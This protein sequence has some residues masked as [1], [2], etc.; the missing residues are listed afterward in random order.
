LLSDNDL[1]QVQAASQQ[2]TGPVTIRVSRGGIPGPFEENLINTCRQITGVSQNRIELEESLDSVIPGK[3]SLTIVGAGVP[4][5]HYLAVPEG[6]EFAPF[7]DALMWVGGAKQ[8]TDAEVYEPLRAVT[9]P[10]DLLVLIAPVCPH[11]PQVVRAAVSVGVH[12]SLVRV[13]VGDALQF[14]D[15]AEQ[16]KVKS[17][18]TTVID[19]GLTIVG[20]VNAP[21]LVDH[22]VKSAVGDSLT[23]ILNSMVQSGRAEDAASILCRES[24]PEAILPLYAA[25]EFSLR[26]GALLVMETALEHD[27]RILDA[28]VPNLAALLEDQEVG[29]RG[30]TAELL[31]KIGHPAAVPSLEKVLQDPDVDVREAVEEALQSIKSSESGPGA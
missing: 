22:I 2:M 23:E 6:H 8:T 20:Q 11:C 18:P 16:F 26:M 10:V 21:Q 29:L 14:P 31:G 24:R 15:L 5:V 30:D 19:G 13:T 9:A 7:L 25:K 28:I 3:P 4:N 27:P 1:M 17:T 12:C